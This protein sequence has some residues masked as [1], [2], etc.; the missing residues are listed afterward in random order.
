M[1]RNA[2]YWKKRMEAIEDASHASGLE[3]ARYAEEQFRKAQAAIEKEINTWYARLAYNNDANLSGAK[4]LLQ[5][6]ELEEFHWEV[7]EYIE[8]GKTLEYTD[9]W[10]KALENASAKVHISRLEAMKIQMQQQCEALYGNV[11]VGLDEALKKIY[12]EGYYHTAYEIQKGTSVGWGF[13]RLDD[14]KID[15]A[16]KT[17]WT[18]DGKTYSDR[19]WQNKTKLV[20][21]LNTTLTQSIIRGDD[22]QKAIRE[23]SKRMEVSKNNAG[24]LIMTETAAIS[25]M[26]QREC[27]R[28]L[29][30]EEFEFVATL[31][32]HTSD[33]C[34]SMD[35][36]HFKMSDFQVGL[37]APPLH[38]W[39]RSCTAPYFDDEF[40]E[41]GQRAVRGEDG[42]TYYVP[43]DM[44]YE[45]WK[46][47]YVDTQGE[48]DIIKAVQIPP[49]IKNITGI[50]PDIINDIQG[51]IRDIEREYDIRLSRILVEDMRTEKPNTPYL[52]RYSEDKGRHEAVLVI[53]SGYD[54]SG[55]EDVVSE[56]YRVGYFA[57]KNI[58]DHIIHEMA[59]VMTGQNLQNADEF[60]DFAKMIEN[61]YV[62]GVSGY[63]DIAKDGFETIAEAFVRIRNGEEVPEKARKLV[64][65]YIERWRKK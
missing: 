36:K 30:V 18:N 48:I 7:W 16:L 28:E 13:Q 8:K 21:E 11:S 41:G 62:M 6:N 23:L 45:E 17:C 2:A 61:D 26:S 55:F 60:A 1:K 58:K 65:D 49:E 35:G 54:F 12:T 29:D 64:E 44:K 14:R 53:N 34:R 56:G 37:N 39:C 5:K 57:G 52:C 46:K 47:I 32:S 9:Q 19:I 50:T 10:K 20:N 25:S 4:R 31:D 40:T 33:I 27:F 51:G 38:C 24:R 22:P 43:A 15:K 3:Y 63:S 59:H 42:K